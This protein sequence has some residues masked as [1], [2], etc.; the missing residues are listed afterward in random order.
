MRLISIYLLSLFFSFQALGKITILEEQKIIFNSETGKLSI[1]DQDPELA[2]EIKGFKLEN[3]EGPVVAFRTENRLL[4]HLDYKYFYF[5]KMSTGTW[6]L[7][8]SAVDGLS[9]KDN[10]AIS[11]VLFHNIE[12]L[13]IYI[14][15]GYDNSKDKI[16]YRAIIDLERFSVQESA[17]I[18]ILI[19]SWLETARTSSK[20]FVTFF[21]ENAPELYKKHVDLI[22]QQLQGSEP[23]TSENPG[24]ALVTTSPLDDPVPLIIVKDQNGLQVNAWD[25]IGEFSQDMLEQVKDFVY[26]PN[27]KLRSIEDQILKNFLK[28]EA[29]SVKLLAP[30]GVGKTHLMMRI[31]SR[32]LN[33]DVPE[34]TESEV[35]PAQV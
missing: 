23:P 35:Y 14:F 30:A 1:Y 34:N 24:T 6:Q 16:S 22:H 28:F 18:K 5:V 9:K 8:Q 31:A 20:D 19:E 12:H 3:Y 13:G 10:L 7:K 4:V 33:G 25:Y 21:K 11:H 15:V 29:G 2:T 32:F 27:E 26:T 17:Y